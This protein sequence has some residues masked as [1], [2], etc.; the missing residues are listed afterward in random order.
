MTSPEESE[1][2]ASRGM[3]VP[4]TR[5][6]RSDLFKAVTLEASFHAPP[7]GRNNQS[8]CKQTSGATGSVCPAFRICPACQPG[9]TCLLAVRQALR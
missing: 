3:G 4:V 2:V 5:R 8:P 7:Q 6:D 1:P 9:P